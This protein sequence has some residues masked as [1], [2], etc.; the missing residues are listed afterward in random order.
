MGRRI[1]SPPSP[2]TSDSTPPCEEPDHEPVSSDPR[3]TIPSC[4]QQ[5]TEVPTPV[6][7]AHE[8]KWEHQSLIPAK[9]QE[10]DEFFDMANELGKRPVVAVDCRSVHAED[11]PRLLQYYKNYYVQFNLDAMIYDSR[12]QQVSGSAKFAIHIHKDLDLN[13]MD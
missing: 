8:Q 13:A 3:P 10:I 12:Y 2:R 6:W 7:N 9:Q 5:P 1:G 11:R 4:Y